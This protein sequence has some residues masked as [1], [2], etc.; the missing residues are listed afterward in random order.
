VVADAN[1]GSFS[2]AFLIAAAISVAGLGL[3]GAHALL[4]RRSVRPATNQAEERA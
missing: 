3:V 1:G 4:R 2:K